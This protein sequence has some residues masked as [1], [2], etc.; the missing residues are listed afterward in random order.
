MQ[1]YSQ[2]PYDKILENFYFKDHA[3]FLMPPSFMVNSS[4]K[5]IILN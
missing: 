5:S 3:N 1:I 2:N 4:Q